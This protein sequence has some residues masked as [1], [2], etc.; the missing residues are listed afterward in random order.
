MPRCSLLDFPPDIVIKV[1]YYS[2]SF[3][4]IAL[5]QTCISLSTLSRERILWIYCLNHL[6]ET[7]HLYPP[8]FPMDEMTTEQL[9][10][11]ANAPL[12][13]RCN[14]ANDRKHLAQKNGTQSIQRGLA[15]VSAAWFLFLAVVIL[16][17]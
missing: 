4:R 9:E 12:R 6:I 8:S 2:T 5:R 17:L 1:L 16:L 14:L 15:N 7:A 3:A 10:A 13:F 11:A